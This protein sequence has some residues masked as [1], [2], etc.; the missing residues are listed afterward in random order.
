MQQNLD[1]YEKNGCQIRNQRA[2]N[3][4]NYHTHQFCISKKI[5]KI[6]IAFDRFA[7]EIFTAIGNRQLLNQMSSFRHKL[8]DKKQ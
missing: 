5:S 8:L 7:T 3:I 6:F 4:E 1:V 2:K